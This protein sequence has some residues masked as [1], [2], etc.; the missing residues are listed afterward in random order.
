MAT[1]E[2]TSPTTQMM[3]VHTSVFISDLE[4]KQNTV[5]QPSVSTATSVP[6]GAHGNAH[7]QSFSR[8]IESESLGE[9]PEF[10]FPQDS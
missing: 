1:I 7:C 10:A 4:K 9:P 3:L 8:P 2:K 6:L 5:T